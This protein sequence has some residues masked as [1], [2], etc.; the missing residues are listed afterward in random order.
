M[1]RQKSELLFG[2]IVTELWGAF[3]LYLTIWAGMAGLLAHSLSTGLTCGFV[4]GII[5]AVWRYIR[6]LRRE[7]ELLEKELEKAKSY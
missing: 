1:T 3:F 5:E 4:V 6:Y 2:N 7:I